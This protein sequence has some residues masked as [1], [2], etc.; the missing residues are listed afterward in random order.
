MVETSF[1][2]YNECSAYDSYFA[3][4]GQPV[5]NEQGYTMFKCVRCGKWS[6]LGSMKPW[7]YECGIKSKTYRMNITCSVCDHTM[8]IPAGDYYTKEGYVRAVEEMKRD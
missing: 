8:H 5:G 3:R 4:H 2:F 7:S 6:D 1:R